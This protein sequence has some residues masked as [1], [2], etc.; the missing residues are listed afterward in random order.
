M[1]IKHDDKTFRN[2][3][4]RGTLKALIPDLRWAALVV[5][6]LL[7][8]FVTCFRG[9]M[10]SQIQKSY[11]LLHRTVTIKEFRLLP[12][13]AK[14]PPQPFVVFDLNGREYTGFQSTYSL[15]VGQKVTAYYRDSAEYGIVVDH[16]EPISTLQ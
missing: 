6:L 4:L 1:N 11:P 2:T 15:S 3:Y 13:S 5:G 9:G 16:V 12:I 10:H 8:L 14:H 7:F